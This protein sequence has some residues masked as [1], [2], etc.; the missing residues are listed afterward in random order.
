MAG[1]SGRPRGRPRKNP[2]ATSATAPINSFTR[3]SKQATVIEKD[4]TDITPITPSVRKRKAARSPEP[5]EVATTPTQRKILSTTA[6]SSKK[7]RLQASEPNVQIE[8]QST[9]STPRPKSTKKR[10][11]SPMPEESPRT[12]EAG[13]LFKRLCLDSTPRAARNPSPLITYTTTCTSTPATS[14][15]PDSDSENDADA[16]NLTT[17]E[18]DHRPLPQELLDL[19][20]LYVAFLKTIVL[21]YAHNGTNTPVDLREISQP[22]SVAWGKRRIS[23]ADVRRCIGVMDTSEASPFSLVNYGAKKVCVELRKHYQGLPLDESGLVTVFE[24]NLRGIWERVKEVTNEDMSGFVMSLPKAPVQSCES[25]AK[26]SAMFAKGQRAMEELKKGIAAKNAQGAAK[27]ATLGT[28]I[29]SDGTPLKLSLLERLRLKEEQ[30]ANLEASGPTSAE[31]ERQAALQ[32]ADD[33]AAVIAMLAKSASSAGMGGRVSFTMPIL[34]QKLKDSLRVP[35]SKEEGAA[36]VRLLAGEVAPEW[37]KIVT[38]GAK[39]NVVI[40]VG[41]APSSSLVAERVKMLSK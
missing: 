23:L 33:I 16:S 27:N 3:V 31:L 18:P 38:I 34:L 20:S 21:H 14:V 11:L 2:I 17:P 36:C 29:D 5:E 10:A 40:T 7:A 19:V 22:V 15:A 32:R 12:K 35:V 13:N 25:I 1:A 26:A 41:R 39:E 24:N 6:K 37:L 30:L 4:V 8:E 9:P 28:P